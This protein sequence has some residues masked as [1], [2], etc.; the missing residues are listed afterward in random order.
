MA[1]LIIGT[2]D[3][4]GILLPSVVNSSAATITAIAAV[5]G[6]IIRV[7]KMFLVLSG[8]STVTLQDGNGNALSGPMSMLANGSITFMHDGQP[9]FVTAAG[10]SFQ[11]ANSGSVQISGTLYYTQTAFIN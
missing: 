9:W 6:Q 1:S 3:G 7:Y 4:S 2:R 11:I 8:V 10:A 5:T